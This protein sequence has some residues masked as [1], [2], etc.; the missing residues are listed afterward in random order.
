MMRFFQ[1]FTTF[2]VILFYCAY[3]SLFYVV[4]KSNFIFNRLQNFLCHLNAV[5]SIS[6]GNITF[7]CRQVD[8]NSIQF[9]L[10]NRAETSLFT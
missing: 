4:T 10:H 5:S 8:L 1:I 3:Y 6:L 9:F 7:L 2:M